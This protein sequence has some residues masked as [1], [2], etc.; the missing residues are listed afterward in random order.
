MEHRNYAYM[1]KDVVV[2]DFKYAWDQE[3]LWE[4]AATKCVTTYKMSDVK[5]WVYRPCWSRGKCLVS[6]YQVLLQPKLFANH[7]KR[8]DKADT[9]YPLIVV[10]DE[11]DKYGV[12]LDGNHRFAKLVLANKRNVKVVKFTT[13]DL[14]RLR[15]KV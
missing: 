6:I 14:G 4:K 5:H 9:K 1:L 13:K 7:T 8:I 3:V 2:G 10:Q 11:F 12:I 15:I